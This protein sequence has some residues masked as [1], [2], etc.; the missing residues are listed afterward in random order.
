MDARDERRGPLKLART[1]SFSCRQADLKMHMSTGG[2]PGASLVRSNSV[3]SDGRLGCSPTN[4]C[5]S[6]GGLL[7]SDATVVSDSRQL[8]RQDSVVSAPAY[9]G[10][11]QG[12]LPLSY[13]HQTYHYKPAG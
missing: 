5:A 7:G 2:S 4:S 6:D 1:D 12:R 8:M 11:Q 3:V 9:P 10:S 13:H